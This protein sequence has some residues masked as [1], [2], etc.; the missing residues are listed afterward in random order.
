MQILQLMGSQWCV[1]RVGIGI[2]QFLWWMVARLFAT[3]GFPKK[4][5]TCALKTAFFSQPQCPLKFSSASIAYYT[6]Y[7]TSKSKI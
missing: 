1:L 2:G 4:N 5:T 3:V 7:T 6:S